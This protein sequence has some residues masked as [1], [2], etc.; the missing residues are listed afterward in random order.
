[1]S[2]GRL[3][4]HETDL[5]TVI[6]RFRRE[7]GENRALLVYYSIRNK[8]EERSSDVI[9]LLGTHKLFAVLLKY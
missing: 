8:P 2:A 3:A 5:I 9:G 6:S 7:V 1:M 4:F